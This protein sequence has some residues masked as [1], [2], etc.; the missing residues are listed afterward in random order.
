M[1]DLSHQF[2]A[3]FVLAPNGALALVDGPTLGQQRVLRRL[4]TN[5]GDYIWQR[6]YGAG[7]GAMVG[8]PVN[9]ARTRAVI[10][11]Q[12]MQESLV[13]RQPPPV[14]TVA[15]DNAGHV[16]ANVSYADATTGA[17]QTLPP[18]PVV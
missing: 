4:L 5:P 10:F 1:P 18:I 2:G 14:V 13:A 7:L 6:C 16:F 8:R 11:A 9:A 12:M 3:D 17:T 15:A